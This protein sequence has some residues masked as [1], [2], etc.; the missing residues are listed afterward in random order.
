[1][2]AELS[3]RR[4]VFLYGLLCVLLIPFVFPTWWMVTSSVK[5]ISDIFAFPPQLVP[6][7]YDWTTYSK[8]FELQP[9]VKQYWNSAYIAALVTVG[10]MIVSSMAGYAFARIRFPFANTIFM[11]VLL[12]L[13]IPS[14]VTIVPLF[15][16]FLK[17]GMVNTHWP[18]IL[19]PI[20]GAPSVFATFVMRQ[21]FIALPDELEE[22]AR[23]DGLGRFKI[24][25]KI[26]LPLA[27]P[28]LASVAIFT[29]LHS[30]N[31][32]L[33]PIVFLSSADK[34]TLPQA[35]TQYTDAY[36]GPMWNIQLAAATLT[37]LP[38]LIVFIIAQKQ[39]VEGLAHTGL[40]G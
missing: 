24:F 16:M 39:F 14:E 8:V 5:P 35:L 26:A 37:A 7:N 36:G 23:V 40:K 34:F 30:W 4:Q 32:Y 3:P 20:F 21:F 2:K 1:M 38:V 15:Q 12:G 19:V 17:A 29:F 27:R 18:L 31:L 10:T 33:E 13:L 9:F 22:A 25:R 28:A 11:V 6:E